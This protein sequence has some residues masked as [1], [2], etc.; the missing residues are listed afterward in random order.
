MSNSQ[1]EL[2]GYSSKYGRHQQWRLGILQSEGLGSTSR[3]NR[4]MY[5]GHGV[6]TNRA[7]TSVY[8]MSC[9]SDRWVEHRTGP[10][11]H[12]GIYWEQIEASSTQSS[13]YHKY[14]TVVAAGPCRLQRLLDPQW[15]RRGF[16]NSLSPVKVKS[17]ATASRD[18]CSR[19]QQD[20]WRQ[21]FFIY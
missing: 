15:G 20:G 4:S 16:L 1:S 3:D 14:V 12:N 5:C 17:L 7:G 9:S 11:I 10:Q 18:R 13:R 19:C 21:S 8:S 6:S 2:T